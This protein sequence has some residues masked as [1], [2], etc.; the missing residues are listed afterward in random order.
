MTIPA[1]RTWNVFCPN[2]RLGPG[3]MTATLTGMGRIADQLHR[4]YAGPAWHGPSLK[5]LLAGL[6]REVRAGQIALLKKGTPTGDS[7]LLL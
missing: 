1:R 4:S 6:E 7:D 2:R 5:E 3:K